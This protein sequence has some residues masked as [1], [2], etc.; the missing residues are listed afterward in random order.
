MF[1]KD[2][3]YK[4]YHEV[5]KTTPNVVIVKK[6]ADGKVTFD[7][8]PSEEDLKEAY[9]ALGSKN[10]FLMR[11]NRKFFGD[12]FRYAVDVKRG[13]AVLQKKDGSAV[14]TT[15]PA[16]NTTPKKVKPSLPDP[17]TIEYNPTRKNLFTVAINGHA[18]LDAFRKSIQE[19][20]A[21]ENNKAL[22]KFFKVYGGEFDLL[23]QSNARQ[24]DLST[25]RERYGAAVGSS[26]REVELRG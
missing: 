3:D 17:L 24:N 16:T 6:D 10:V 9:T 15:I 8:S 21:T 19:G 22:V 14:T 11:L 23:F 5:E 18:N 2:G 1:R 7:E 20:T 25:F 4:Y 12:Q 13:V 26:T